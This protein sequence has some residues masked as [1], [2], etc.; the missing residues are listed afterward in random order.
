MK[1]F[2]QRIRLIAN[3]RKTYGKVK[4]RAGFKKQVQMLP[5]GNPARLISLPVFVRIHTV[6]RRVDLF[7]FVSS[8]SREFLELRQAALGRRSKGNAS[9]FQHALARFLVND[10]RLGE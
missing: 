1:L 4:R 3:K 6:L 8:R 5:G 10:T 7:H 2:D 9:D